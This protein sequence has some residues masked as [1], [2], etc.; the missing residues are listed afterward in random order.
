MSSSRKDREKRVG[1]EM[2]KGWVRG[3]SCS[4]VC[5]IALFTGDRVR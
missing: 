3:Q 4:G 5:T 2:R 1:R